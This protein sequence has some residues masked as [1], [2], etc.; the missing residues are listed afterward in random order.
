MANPH[1]YFVEER[2]DGTVAVKGQECRLRY[3]VEATLQ[4]SENQYVSLPVPSIQRCI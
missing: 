4:I 3:L 2:K 1:R